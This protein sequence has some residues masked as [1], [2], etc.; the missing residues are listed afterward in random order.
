MNHKKIMTKN[1]IEILISNENE[2]IK[3]TVRLMRE[4]GVNEVILDSEDGTSETGI[5]TYDITG[6]GCVTEIISR[7]QITE[8]GSLKLISDTERVIHD[9]ECPYGT[10]PYV[11]AAVFRKLNENLVKFLSTAI[12]NSG[13]RT[14]TVNALLEAG[15]TDMADIV[16]SSKTYFERIRG[17]S[18]N[19]VKEI[20]Q[21]LQE[22]GVDFRTDIRMLG[23]RPKENLVDHKWLI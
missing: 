8:N 17:I 4:K 18:M 22:K 9:N 21:M 12:R 6:T 5:Y 14:R 10:F 20:R 2:C 13:L 1:Y 15:Y 11:H 23:F 3:E 7:V 16:M 19:T